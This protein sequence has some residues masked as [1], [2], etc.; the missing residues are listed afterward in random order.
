MWNRISI[1]F[2]KTLKGKYSVQF[3]EYCDYILQNNSKLNE[4]IIRNKLQ[5]CFRD[6]IV[7]HLLPLIKTKS[8]RE[9][10]INEV[11]KYGNIDFYVNNKTI[12]RERTKPHCYKITRIND[13]VFNVM[14][15]TK[16]YDN[17]KLKTLYYFVDDELFLVEKTMPSD[18]NCVNEYLTNHIVHKYD[19]NDTIVIDKLL[20]SG[21]NSSFISIDDDG[22]KLHIKYFSKAKE[23]VNIK[24]N[25]ALKQVFIALDKQKEYNNVVLDL[26]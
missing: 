15:Y 11:I 23:S 19:L 8:S 10:A 9:I 2:L 1:L 17:M 14:G 20:I 13:S 3:N 26:I 5:S 22:F 4:F 21:D 25:D 6:E 18:N 24:I 16:K 7:D 12:R